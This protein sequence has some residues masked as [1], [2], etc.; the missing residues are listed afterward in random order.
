MKGAEGDV[1]AH[2]IKNHLPTLL[3]QFDVEVEQGDWQAFLKDV[4]IQM[5]NLLNESGIDTFMSGSTLALAILFNG[6]AYLANIGDSKAYL[7]MQESP[8]NPMMQV[9]QV[10]TDH[11]CTDERERRR[12]ETA[13][14][15]VDYLFSDGTDDPGPLRIFKGTLPY[16]GLVVSRSLGDSSVSNVGVIPEPS[17][18]HVVLEPKHKLLILASDGVSDGIRIEELPQIIAQNS[19]TVQDLAN[20][21]CHHSLSG[22]AAQQIDDNTTN[23]VI[24]LDW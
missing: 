16:P 8:H 10:S 7:C 14:G 19:T 17:V 4:C 12:V 24:K 20:A 18:S 5:N 11:L 2:Y 13:G 6:I 3:K 22:L 1:V 15:R 21:I 9:T 23:I